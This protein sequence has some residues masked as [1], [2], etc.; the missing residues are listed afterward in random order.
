MWKM[1]AIHF[2]VDNMTALTY[3]LKMGWTKNP[4]LMQISKE[5][6]EFIQGIM[7]T[8]EN[9]PGNLN[10]QASWESRHRKDSSEW[11]LC[12]LVFSKICQ[13]LGKKPE[14]DLLALRLSNQLPSYYSLKPD[15][16]SLGT[17]APQ[18]KWYHKSLYAF[19]SFAFLYK[20]LKKVEEEKLPS[21]IIVTPTWQT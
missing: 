10:C 17:D 8:V 5:I 9:L 20:V 4:E 13:I 11:K 1:L 2:Q 7:I 3:L 19:H 16:D 15:S 6:W 21:L 12:P 18:Q 14:I